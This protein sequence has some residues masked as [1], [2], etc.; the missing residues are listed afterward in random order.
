MD[1]QKFAS[2]SSYH[3]HPVYPPIH[4]RIIQQNRE[5]MIIEEDNTIYEIDKNCAIQH[6]YMKKENTGAAAENSNSSF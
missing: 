3:K 5:T 6:G 2:E 4:S 1:N